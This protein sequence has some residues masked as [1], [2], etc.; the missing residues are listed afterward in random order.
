MKINE[1]AKLSG[2]NA[3]TIRKYRD[4]GLLK[5]KRNPENGYYEYSSA[6][7][8]NLLYIRKLRGANLSLDAIESSCLRGDAETLLEGYRKTICDLEEEIRQLRRREMMLRI[9]ARHYE[10]DAENT[11]EIR[12]ID[13]FDTKYDCYFGPEPPA[14]TLGHWVRNVDLFTLVICIEKRWFEEAEL[15]E[16]VPVRVGLGTYEE[17]LREEKLPVPEEVRVFP[18]GKYVSFF[19]RLDELDSVE[20][21]R[22]SAVREFLQSRGLKPESDSTAYLYRV[23][24]ASGTPVFVFCVRV[25]VSGETEN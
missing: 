21:S 10:R 7:F 23:D 5:P 13:A 14:G 1:L 6:D 15:P 12:V 4:R 9:T 2:L 11:G 17:V 19:L 25:L 20:S 16:R 18:R 8:L 24:T 3:E 22:L